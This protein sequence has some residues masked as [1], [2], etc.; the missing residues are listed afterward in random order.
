[1]KMQ[2]EYDEQEHIAQVDASNHSL[3]GYPQTISGAIELEQKRTVSWKGDNHCLSLASNV[4]YAEMKYST[5]RII[6]SNIY[7]PL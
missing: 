2:S 6:L 4:F 3:E 7:H 5:I 1:M